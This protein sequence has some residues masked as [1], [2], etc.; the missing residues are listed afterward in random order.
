V[1]L[2][3]INGSLTEEQYG[4][5]RLFFDIA[6]NMF[7][8][9]SLGIIPVLFKFYPY[10]KD[11]LLPKENDLLARALIT[12]IIGFAIVL[13]VSILFKEQVIHFFNRT[14]RSPLINDYFIW[15][16]PFAAGML[17]FSLLEGYSWALKK[18]ILPAFL[19]ETFFRI[20]T[21]SILLLFFFRIIS[22]D[23]FIKL[24]AFSYFVIFLILL[25]YLI[26]TGHFHLT[27]HK[28]RVTKKFA[29]KMFGMQSLIFGG[30]LISALGQTIDGILIAS[31]QG[32]GTAAIFTVAQYV[33]NLV[34]VPQRS[35]QSISTG[36]LSQAWKDK[37][38]KEINRIYGR[39]SINLLI[40][41]LFIYGN[42]VLNIRPAIELIG[43]QASY[44]AGIQTLFILG[45]AR[46]IDAGTGVNGTIIATSTFWK[47][48]F[49]SG[50]VMLALMI[51]SNYFLIKEYGIIGSAYAQIISMTV[52]NFIRWEFLRRKFN[53]QPF[54]WKTLYTLLWS[55]GSF[56][57]VYYTMQSLTGW[58][59]LFARAIS[60]SVLM[61]AGVFWLRLT[62]DA[63]Q[64]WEK[65]TKR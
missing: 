23:T 48:D 30:I 10:Y 28:S 25:I 40:M 3:T 14:R 63:L 29:K 51:P 13:V 21:T 38:Y 20:V 5:T 61:I 39:T 47:F 44:L 52:Y 4:L 46:I 43:M 24:F 54:T 60:F 33:A 65:W 64:L 37:D 6:Q 7:A 2:S 17:F 34:Q 41:A 36:V 57:L 19:K 1:Y 22:F 32:L 50:V 26:R 11:N 56:L 49:F 16:F 31:L 45:I 59:G 58:L 8:F 55:L 12:A 18:T 62:P 15:I 9:G 53:M 42:V 35:M 27:F